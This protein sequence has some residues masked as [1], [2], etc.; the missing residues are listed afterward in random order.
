[1]D[2]EILRDGIQ[3]ARERI[4][5]DQ[6]YIYRS[7]LELARAEIA[8]LRAEVNV[9]EAPNGMAVGD[10]VIHVPGNCNW[11][12]RGAIMNPPSGNRQVWIVRIYNQGVSAEITPVRGIGA[13]HVYVC[14]VKD[15]RPYEGE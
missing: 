10:K 12:F 1:M 5:R 11:L 2:N 7:E 8:R 6:E 4:Q 3:A 9:Y 14:G 13:G 15:L